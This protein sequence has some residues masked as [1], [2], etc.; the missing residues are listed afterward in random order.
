MCGR[1]GRTVAGEGGWSGREPRYA[2]VRVAGHEVDVLWPDAK[3][4]VEVDGYAFHSTRA[5]FE[6]DRRRDGE[7]QAA[8]YRVLRLTWRQL[9]DEPEAVVASLA[10][11]L[12]L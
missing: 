6:R 8:G 4:V 2:N 11:T 9:A 10:R 12:A 1:R 7:L 3:L 5:A